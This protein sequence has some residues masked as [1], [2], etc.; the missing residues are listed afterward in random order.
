VRITWVNPCFLHYRIP[1]YAELSRL[2]GDEFHLVFSATR[3]PAS[4]QD[5]IREV[6]GDRAIALQGERC[7]RLG[8]GSEGFANR[9]LNI[10]YQPGLKQAI[11]RT[12]PEVVIG[13]GFFQ[14]T[15]AALSVA[16][17]CGAAT[18]IA[19]EKTAH[20]ERRAGRLRTWY[21]RRLCRLIDAVACNGSLSK[22]YCVEVLGMSSDRV[23]TGA[24]AAETDLL[25]QQCRKVSQAEVLALSQ[26][27]GLSG[28]VFMFMGRLIRLKGLDELLGAWAQYN[29]LCPE[30]SG[31]LLLVGEGP[32]R[33][34]LEAMVASMRLGNVVFAGAVQYDD[35]AQ[36]YSL[37]DV[38]VMP[39]LEDNWSLVV[40]EAMACGKPIMC[41][42]YNGCW[43]ELVR[44]GMN[45]YVFDPLQSLQAAEAMLKFRDA[46]ARAAMGE[47][48]KEIVKAY[49]P[50]RAA[51]AI[52]GAC[53]A[54]REFRLRRGNG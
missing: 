7:L 41:S 39:T 9:G 27:L 3:T 13:E 49:S 20:T 24:M 51:A 18:V 44:Q 12:Q 21:R 33:A 17:K 28:P 11:R 36:Y 1:V 53:Q 47:A 26:S 15:P 8:S 31:S 16:G 2:A 35:V 29:C 14:W 48:S 23:F 46:S 45:G 25:A 43:P 54:A 32:R 52:W 50:A 10:P 6:L 38:L 22:Q 30:A 19:Y 34:H 40:P 42:K 5:R 4:V 37:A